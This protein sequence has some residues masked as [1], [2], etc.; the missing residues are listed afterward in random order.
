M[1]SLTT[2]YSI[3]QQPQP[4]LNSNVELTIRQEKYL[5]MLIP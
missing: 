3:L 5:Q 4:T 2:S 1:P